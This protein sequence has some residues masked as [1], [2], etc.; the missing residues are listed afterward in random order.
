M[1]MKFKSNKSGVSTDENILIELQNSFEFNVQK[2]KEYD[3]ALKHASNNYAYTKN[4][5]LRVSSRMQKLCDSCIAVGGTDLFGIDG[6]EVETTSMLLGETDIVDW[7]SKIEALRH[8]ELFIFHQRDICTMCSS[9]PHRTDLSSL[10]DTAPPSQTTSTLRKSIQRRKE[11]E[12]GVIAIHSNSDADLFANKQYIRQGPRRQ[13]GRPGMQQMSMDDESSDSPAYPWQYIRQAPRRKDDKPQISRDDGS[14]FCDLFLA[15]DQN[16][17]LQAR[18]NGPFGINRSQEKGPSLQPTVQT[19]RDR[20]RIFNL[21]EAQRKDAMEEI[22]QLYQQYVKWVACHLDVSHEL[23]EFQKAIVG[24][25]DQEEK[26]L[27]QRLNSIRAQ[28]GS[29][30]QNEQIDNETSRLCQICMVQPRS[31]CLI[32]C[33]HSMICFECAEKM[34][35]CPWCDK[36]IQ[37]KQRMFV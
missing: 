16:D 5:F 18:R 2:L 35:K 30:N 17:D 12:K 3:V 24:V 36:D 27:L 20:E 13:D 11:L 9:P 8:E 10:K 33:G 21:L 26:A 19:P 7:E 25:R 4:R 6:W 37:L 32:P 23:N 29:P 31:C 14:A 15:S 34:N 1:I 28:K 22:Q